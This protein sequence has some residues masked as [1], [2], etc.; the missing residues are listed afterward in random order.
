MSMR[1]GLL[2]L[3][4]MLAVTTA[5]AAAP[6]GPPVDPL[7][8]GR[9]PDPVAREFYQPEVVVAGFRGVPVFPSRSVP[10]L[11]EK[12]AADVAT[13]TRGV[14]HAIGTS[15]PMAPVASEITTPLADFATGFRDAVLNGMTVP[16]GTVRIED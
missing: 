7:V 14:G 6:P 9:E 13:P 4:A 3:A 1:N 12:L 15:L 2:G 11:V 16:L 8:D 10:E 5:A